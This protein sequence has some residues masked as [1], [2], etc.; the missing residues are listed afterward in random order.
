M[1]TM[2]SQREKTES[3]QQQ[4]SSRTLTTVL[5]VL[6]VDAGGADDRLATSEDLIAEITEDRVGE[7]FFVV[8]AALVELLQLLQNF[9]LV[10][11]Q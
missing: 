10:A 7:R 9:S 3:S 5:E 11:G 4:K 1:M 6:G 2:L 8:I